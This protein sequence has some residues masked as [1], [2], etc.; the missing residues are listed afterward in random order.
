MKITAGVSLEFVDISS[1]VVASLA[2]R[3]KL[4]PD[5]LYD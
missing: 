4:K 5:P 1:R 3:K 2:N